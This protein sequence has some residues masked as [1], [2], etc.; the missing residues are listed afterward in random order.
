MEAAYIG[1]KLWAQAVE[2]AKT[3]D[4]EVVRDGNRSVDQ[5][6]LAPEGEVHIDPATRH[7]YKTPRIGQ[8]ERRRANSRS[9]GRQSSPWRRSRFRRRAPR[10]NGRHFWTIS[11]H[12]WGDRWSARPRDSRC[13]RRQRLPIV[14]TVRVRAAISAYHARRV[15]RPERSFRIVADLGDALGFGGPRAKLFRE[16]PCTR[17][18]TNQELCGRQDRTCDPRTGNCG[19][20]KAWSVIRRACGRCRSTPGRFASVA[21]RAWPSA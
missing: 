21:A 1:V 12:G 5:N 7:A 17:C 3:D 8:I 15:V 13:D 6:L 14:P 16:R 2:Q 9:S 20:S 4:A 11:T 10:S 19:I 18:S